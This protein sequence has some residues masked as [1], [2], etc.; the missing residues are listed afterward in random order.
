MR[1]I[2]ISQPKNNDEERNLTFLGHS[3]EEGVETYKM[4]DPIFH[5]LTV[6]TDFLRLDKN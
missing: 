5:R 4:H 2:S 1:M 3:P 6:I